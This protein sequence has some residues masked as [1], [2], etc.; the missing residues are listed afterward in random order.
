MPFIARSISRHGYVKSEYAPDLAI[1]MEELEGQH[2][3]QIAR[4]FRQVGTQLPKETKKLLGIR[5]N[6]DMTEQAMNA[7]TQRGLSEPLKS[8]EVTLLDASFDYFRHRAAKDVN[9]PEF[10]GF[11]SLVLERHIK[12][13]SACDRLH[14][15]TVNLA[16]LEAIPPSDCI[17]ET[18]GVMV[19]LEVDFIGKGLAKYKARTG[20]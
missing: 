16:D 14:G 20:E 1:M 8:L 18:C 12:N 2:P 7:L 19:R 5:S 4:A 15:T 13:C 9:R 11:A 6:A 17:Q 3:H 10:E